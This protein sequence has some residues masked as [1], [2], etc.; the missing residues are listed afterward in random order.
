MKRVLFR[1]LEP[2]ARFQ[3]DYQWWVKVDRTTAK[4][5]TYEALIDMRPS[6]YVLITGEDQASS[7]GKDDS[8]KQTRKRE[9]LLLVLGTLPESFHWF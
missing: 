6:C 4:H 3:L 1:S 7:S 9:G 5:A 8:L 2:Q